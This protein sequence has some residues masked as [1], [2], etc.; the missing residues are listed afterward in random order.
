[1]K[2]PQTDD[3]VMAELKHD[4]PLNEARRIL[5]RHTAQ[6]ESAQNLDPIE[7]RRREFATVTAIFKKLL[8]AGY[9]ICD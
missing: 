7:M 3:E 1:M 6:M 2:T 5:S 8:A 9:V 4:T